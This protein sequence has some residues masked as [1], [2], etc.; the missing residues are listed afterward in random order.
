M[1]TDKDVNVQD[2]LQKDLRQALHDNDPARVE[3]LLADAVLGDDFRFE[4]I[5]GLIA[6]GDYA[7]LVSRLL[8]EAGDDVTPTAYVSYLSSAARQ[9]RAATT[10]L[11]GA[12]CIAAGI[13]E[14][15]C[16]SLAIKNVPAEKAVDVAQAIV[17]TL[18]TDQQ[19]RRI[20]NMMLFAATDDRHDTLQ[21]LLSAYPRFCAGQ[22]GMILL[23][24]LEDRN[25]YFEGEE[26]KAEYL[27]LLGQVID[28]CR[29]SNDLKALDL[30]MALVAHRVPEGKEYP[31]LL[32]KLVGAGADPFAMKGEAQRFMVKAYEEKDDLSRADKW[33]GWF[34]AR[35]NDYTARHAHAF[36]TQFGDDFRLQ[37]LRQI[38]SDE[39]DSGLQ[40]AAKA[41]R[42][43]LV[44]KNLAA[45]DDLNVED[46]FAKNKRGES[47]LSLAIDRGD[48]AALLSPVYWSR[49]DVDVM[50]VLNTKLDDDR[51]KWIDMDVIAAQIDHHRLQN[52]A[53]DFKPQF[54][55]R[56]RMR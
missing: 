38:A 37:D 4:L 52:L 1:A 19:A 29:D 16:D 15:E 41:R 2:S 53:E 44:M 28:A 42:I 23:M 27:A 8:K 11:M 31:E 26:N 13:A 49:H 46:I 24:L 5:A 54:R 21:G 9:G 35:M 25:T 12:K 14:S 47:M 10:A 51:K 55:L 6:A 30:V 3:S 43:S 32:E 18:S 17:S 56:P 36:D 20:G 50:A 22:G 40:L 7:A 45:D 48:A 34:D 39:G 33:R